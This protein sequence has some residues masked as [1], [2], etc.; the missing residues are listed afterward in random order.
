M[1]II[2][3]TQLSAFQKN[4]L[5]ALLK[6]CREAEPLSLSA[7]TEDGLEYFLLYEQESLISFLLLFFPEESRCECSAFTLPLYRKRG[8][9]SDLLDAAFLFLDAYEEL[10]LCETTFYFLCDP[11]TPSAQAVLRTIGAVY[12]YEEYKMVRPLLPSDAAY[13]AQV[14]I[15]EAEPHIFTAVLSGKIIGTCV[16]LPSESEVYFYGFE[17][18]EEV[19]RCGYGEDFLLG[20]LAKLVGHTANLTL[21][22]SGQ[23]LPALSLYQKTGFQI[24][25]TLS[26]Y[27]Y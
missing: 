26:Y 7:P 20:I 15:L 16:L 5:A 24:T 14:T 27:T 6:S 22:V 10:H 23:N 9:F 2:H 25:E 11:H 13:T 1:N 21:Q 4:D 12:Q 8:C 17:I 18:R 19:R 3:T